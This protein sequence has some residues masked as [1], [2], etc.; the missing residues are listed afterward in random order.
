MEDY[1]SLLEVAIEKMPKK[2]HDKDRFQIPQAITEIQGN[3]TLIRNFIDIAN[4]LRREPSHIA[5]YLFKELATPG[6]IQGSALILQTKLQQ[7]VV[8]KKIESYV[9]EYVYC[10]VCGEPDTRFAKEGRITYIHCDAC[11]GRSTYKHF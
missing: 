8:Q 1:N 7:N 11:G 9:S 5:K 6:T 2:T 4:I 10:K 3:K